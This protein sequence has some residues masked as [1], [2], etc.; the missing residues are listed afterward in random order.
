MGH[1]R[2]SSAWGIDE[3]AQRL[4]PYLLGKASDFPSRSCIYSIKRN[5]QRSARRVTALVSDRFFAYGAFATG[6]ES[7]NLF[8]KTS[9]GKSVKASVQYISHVLVGF[10]L[11]SRRFASS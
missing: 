10:L 9:R 8:R 4:P 2:I 1:N 3:K 7:I 11:F 6:R 5:L